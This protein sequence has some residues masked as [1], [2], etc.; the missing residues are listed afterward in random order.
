M[1]ISVCGGGVTNRVKN[2]KGA[3]YRDAVVYTAV[4]L[5]FVMYIYMIIIVG[6]IKPEE[7]SNFPSFCVVC[8]VSPCAIT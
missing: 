3:Y 2:H 8:R 6:E 7:Q 1:L 5:P 4:Y